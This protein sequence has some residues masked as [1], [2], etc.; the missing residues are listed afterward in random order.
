M[1]RGAKEEGAAGC[2]HTGLGGPG[3]G[4]GL[5]LKG[6]QRS[7]PRA[8]HLRAEPGVPVVFSEEVGTGR[9]ETLPGWRWRGAAVV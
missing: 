4:L 3:L 5:T 9:G 2:W 1:P 8:S 7:G 6:A